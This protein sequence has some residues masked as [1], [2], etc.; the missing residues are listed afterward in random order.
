[1]GVLSAF[2][3]SPDS[4]VIQQQSFEH[5]HHKATE[6]DRLQ[7]QHRPS[8]AGFFLSPHFLFPQNLNVLFFVAL[9]PKQQPSNSARYSQHV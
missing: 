1:M 8:V 5:N 9:P 3:F 2:R 4:S 7:S 6:R